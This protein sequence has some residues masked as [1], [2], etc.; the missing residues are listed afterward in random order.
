[1][2]APNTFIYDTNKLIALVPSLLT[3]QT[4]FLDRYFTNIQMSDTE[5]VSIDVEIGKRRM[6]PFVSPL[7]EGKLVEALRMQTNTFKPPYI[8]DGGGEETPGARA[9]ANLVYEMEDQLNMLNRRMEWMAIQEL[10]TGAVTVAG[11][12]FPT[13]TIDFGRDA[14]NTVVLS[15][16]ARWGQTGVSPV[17]SLN[18]WALAMLK[19]SGTQPVDVIMTQGAFDKFLQDPLVVGSVFY[20]ALA[21]SGNVIN[22]GSAVQKG[23]VNRGQWGQYNIWLYNDWYVDD[24]EVEQPMLPNG[25]IILASPELMGIRAFGVIQD[26]DH[27]FAMLPYAPKTW[28]VK[29]PSQRFMMMQ[30]SPLPI[31]ARP[32]ASFSATVL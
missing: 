3:P 6:S 23:G 11:D 4:F 31:P 15:G 8:K 24:N 1:M 27:N 18:T 10:L 26:E 30:S 12:G 16:G 14:G 20:P 2:V 28:T 29:D 5:L 17:A 7:V 19:S 22:P 25:T 32:N 9:Q 13:T 21:G